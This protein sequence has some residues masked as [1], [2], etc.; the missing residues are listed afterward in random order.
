MAVLFRLLYLISV[1][2][3]GWLGLLTRSTAAKDVE[4]LVLR[5][6]VSVLRRQVGRPEESATSRVVPVACPSPSGTQR[7]K[8]AT[9]S[10]YIDRCIE[11]CKTRVIP[12]GTLSFVVAGS[13]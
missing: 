4:L 5:H 1:T 13:S 10:N 2:V 6:E 7:D 8:A 9:W 11:R 12:L 3:F